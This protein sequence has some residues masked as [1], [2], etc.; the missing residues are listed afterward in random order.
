MP[1]A[2]RLV[3]VGVDAERD[4]YEHGAHAG[5]RRQ[6]RFVGG[7]EHHRRSLGRRLAQERLALV[8]A[9]DDDLGSA[10]PGR[11][12]ERELSV[13]GDIRADPSSE[14]SSRST[15]TLANA[16][17]PKAT[18][19]PRRGRHDSARARARSVSSQ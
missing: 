5:R 6:L 10:E 7:I 14:R 16:F 17:V 15:A 2:D 8:V 12:R 1:G 11:P 9:V 18:W 19:P 3:R 4:A 13:G